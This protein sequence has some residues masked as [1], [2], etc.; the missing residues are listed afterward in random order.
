MESYLSCFPPYLSSGIGLCAGLAAAKITEMLE[1]RAAVKREGMSLFWVKDGLTLS[2]VPTAHRWTIYLICIVY[3]VLTGLVAQ[4]LVDF[5]YL[6][7]MLIMGM[8][9]TMTDFKYRVIPNEFVL[10]MLILRVCTL[11]TEPA[12]ELLRDGIKSIIL[13][14]VCFFIFWLAGKMTFIVSLLFGGLEHAPVGYGDLKIA[15]AFGFN[16]GVFQMASSIIIAA[17]IPALL[18]IRVLYR[19]FCDYRKKHQKDPSYSLLVAFIGRE[20]IYVPY[21][22]LL[23]LGLVVSLLLSRTEFGSFLTLL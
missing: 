10:G 12:P 22:P 16:L 1:H 9:L 5:I 21:G 14:A 18:E 11:L 17:L 4:T 13:A 3:G 23:V 15:I 19:M 6:M 20:Q 2:Y 8:S 7:G